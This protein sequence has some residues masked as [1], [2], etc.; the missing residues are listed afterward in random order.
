MLETAEAMRLPEE[1]ASYSLIVIYVVLAFLGQAA[2]GGALLQANLL[3]AWIGW[4][5][6]A[7]NLGGWSPCQS[8]HPAMC[9][10][11]CCTI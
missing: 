10:F 2:I 1:P 6:I 11:R 7:W 3:P 8:P 5:I 9:I 4:L